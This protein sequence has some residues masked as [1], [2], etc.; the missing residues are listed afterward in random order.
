[1]RKKSIQMSFTNKLF[2][3]ELNMIEKVTKYFNKKQPDQFYLDIFT[4]DYRQMRVIP[5]SYPNMDEIYN[6]L[7]MIAFSSKFSSSIFAFKY[8]MIPNKI[9]Q[10][11]KQVIER[12]MQVAPEYRMYSKLPTDGWNVTY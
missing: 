12:L 3:I 4:K 7:L 2:T 1:M 10:Y 11:D 6:N 5:R 8:K 9:S